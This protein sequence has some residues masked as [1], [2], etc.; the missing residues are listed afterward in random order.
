MVAWR[1]MCAACGESIERGSFCEECQAIFDE[2]EA[3]NVRNV[4]GIKV[5]KENKRKDDK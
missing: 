2:I 4:Y 3:R 1:R 5:E